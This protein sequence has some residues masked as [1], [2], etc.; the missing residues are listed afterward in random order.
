MYLPLLVDV[1]Q[2]F[3]DN[4]PVPVDSGGGGGSGSGGSHRSTLI[5]FMKRQRLAEVCKQALRFQGMPN[6]NLIH[7][8]ELAEILDDKLEFASSPV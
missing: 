8:P 7:N 3:H 1:H 6:S 2:Q 5:N 4:V